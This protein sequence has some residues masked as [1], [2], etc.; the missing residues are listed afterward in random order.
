M[1]P[2][3]YIFGMLQ[4]LVVPYINPANQGPGVQTGPTLGIKNFHRLVMEN[5][6][7]FFSETMRPTAHMFG[8]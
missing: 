2:T 6:L 7:I 3:P 8:M 5:T 1:R 4:C